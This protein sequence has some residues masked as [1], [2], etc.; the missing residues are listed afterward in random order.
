MRG[1]GA[2]PPSPLRIDSVN[3]Q[4]QAVLLNRRGVRDRSGPPFSPTLLLT[5][6]CAVVAYDEFVKSKDH[7]VRLARLEAEFRNLPDAEFARLVDALPDEAKTVLTSR[8]G[9]E[10]SVDIPGLRDAMR[11]SRMKGLPDQVAAAITEPCLDA[12]ITALG[13]KA[14]LPSLDDLA[15]VTPG[16]LVVH[17]L[18]TTRLMFAS[19]ALQEAPAAAT[20]MKLLKAN[21][22]LNPSAN[23]LETPA[24]PTLPSL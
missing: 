14:D 23:P 8:S 4:S 19:A 6:P 16:L 9:G 22:A 18:A 24:S 17:G 3:H 15:A 13:D 5:R 20:I 21:A 10:E 2:S 7:V 1:S 11:R 12:C